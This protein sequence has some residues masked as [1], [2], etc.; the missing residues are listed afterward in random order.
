MLGSSTSR[1][2]EMIDV[3][4]S[5]VAIDWWIHHTR[6]PAEYNGAIGRG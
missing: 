5:G 4:S 3:A 6:R 1:A 2:T